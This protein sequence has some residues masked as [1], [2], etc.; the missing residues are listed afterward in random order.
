MISLAQF[1]LNRFEVAM[2]DAIE[3]LETNKDIEMVKLFY[4]I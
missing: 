1:I 4:F 3:N 2:P